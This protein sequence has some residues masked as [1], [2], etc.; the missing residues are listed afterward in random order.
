[1]S[2]N[3][4][5]GEFAR[6]LLARPMLARPIAFPLCD[7]TFPTPIPIRAR[8]SWDQNKLSPLVLSLG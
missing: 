1:M 5:M 8:F 3:E 7:T 4:A 6:P 2:E